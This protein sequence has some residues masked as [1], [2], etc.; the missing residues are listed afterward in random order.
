M[1][2]ADE[3]DHSQDNL[4]LTTLFHPG[5]HHRVVTT[6]LTHYSLTRLYEQVLT[7]PLLGQ[8]ADAPDMA[9]AFGLQVGE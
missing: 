4:V 3:D 2:T 9:A 8:A 7:A 5:Q 1:V 6:P